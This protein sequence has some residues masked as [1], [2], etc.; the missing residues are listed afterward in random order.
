MVNFICSFFTF[1]KDVIK[2]RRILW[3]LAKNDFKAHFASSLLGGFWA[4]A[5]PLVILLV[6]WFVF[7]VGFKNPPID[8]VPFI[9]WFAP[10]YLIWAFF[11]EALLAGTNCVPEYSYLVKKVN[12]R[13]S[14]IPIGKIISSSFI[15][16]VFI[17]FIFF[18][19]LVY[20]IPL[21]IYNL[22]VIY[23]FLCTCFLLLGL[24]WLFSA[25][26]PFVQ[27]VSSIVGIA[28]QVGFW[29][30]P[31]FWSP[32]NMNPIVQNI[33]KINPMFYICRGYRDSFIDHVW[34]WQRGFTNLSFWLVSIICFILGAYLFKKLRPQ[35]AD[36]L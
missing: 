12:F 17:G 11:S 35:F 22:Q 29:I 16:M 2:D 26:V 33:L 18:L 34:F 23:Y 9:V 13:V 28:T 27:D 14:I 1:L 6:F 7:Q 21:S 30:T 36:V 32:D 25:M 24:N 20:K 31:I 5:H 8:S 10:A 15:H 19:L 4:F 3:S